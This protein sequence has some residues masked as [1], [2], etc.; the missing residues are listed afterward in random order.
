MTPSE[1]EPVIVLFDGV[2]NFC[3]HTVSFLFARDK[4]SV[5]RFASLQSDVGQELL[6]K[7]HIPTDITT[8]VVIEK[9]RAYLRSTAALRLTRYLN[10]GWSLCQ[11]LLIIPRPVRDFGYTF[12]A[13]NRYRWFGKSETCPLPSAE[14]R[15]RFLG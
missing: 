9:G 13:N 8:I 14:L 4:A 11:F 6:Q 7:H 1:P 3:N 15:Q 2:C 12:F 10:K 5:F